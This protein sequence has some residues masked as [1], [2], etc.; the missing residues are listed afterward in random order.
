MTYIDTRVLFSSVGRRELELIRQSGCRQFPPRPAHQPVLHPLLTEEHA[1]RIARERH[2]RDE[3]SGFAGFVLR[4]SVKSTFLE[5]FAVEKGESCEALEYR[6][7]AERLP[8]L[9]E[10]IVGVIQMLADY[11][12]QP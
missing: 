8:E 6:I 1:R 2:A 7:P 5:Q 10:N 3:S 9:N 11:Y 4:F 12:G